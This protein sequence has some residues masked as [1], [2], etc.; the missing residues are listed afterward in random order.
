MKNKRVKAGLY[1]QV[2]VVCC[3]VAFVVDMKHDVSRVFEYFSLT[4]THYENAC[5]EIKLTHR[6][7]VGSWKW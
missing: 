2:Y 1:L 6:V 7:T 3:F 4:R 5:S